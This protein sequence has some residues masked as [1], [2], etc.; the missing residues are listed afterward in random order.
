MA[1]GDKRKAILQA[2]L[3][4]AASH[5]L[6]GAS[7]SL[8]AKRS[9]ASPGIIYHYFKN[10]E[11]LIVSLFR[12]LKSEMNS[13]LIPEN[14]TELTPDEAFRSV[15][16]NAYKHY[17]THPAELHFIDQFEHSP[18]YAK[19]SIETEYEQDGRLDKMIN[20]FKCSLPEGSLPSLPASATHEL[21]LGVAAGIAR[22]TLSGG[23]ELSDDHLTIIARA[24][25]ASLLAI[26]QTSRKAPS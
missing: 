13:A 18:C 11:D 1:K 9:G 6:D 2:T 17:I 22:K 3:E 5:G 25:W 24:C 15:W 23:L 14:L 19:V 16:I 12:H 7:M 21:T 4:L 26:C 20:F 8:I 10:K